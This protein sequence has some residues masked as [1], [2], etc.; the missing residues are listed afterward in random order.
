MALYSYKASEDALIS[1]A[2]HVKSA[3][4]DVLVDVGKLS[5]ISC[6]SFP[7]N[8]S[9][10]DF[11]ESCSPEYMRSKVCDVLIN[12]SLIDWRALERES[13]KRNCTIILLKHVWADGICFDNF[14]FWCLAGL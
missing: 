5:P 2:V 14:N 13:V 9:I 11:I 6:F 1:S 12:D 3:L 7:A 10:S 8:I 4:F